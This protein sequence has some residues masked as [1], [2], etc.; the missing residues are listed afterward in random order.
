MTLRLTSLVFS[1]VVAVGAC[2]SA[3]RSAVSTDKMTE[4]STIGAKSQLDPRCVH[5]VAG[6]CD[7]Y[8]LSLIEL[9]AR[10]ERY[11]GRRVEVQ[12]FAN[13]EFEGNGLYVSRGDWENNVTKNAI[14]LDEPP[15]SAR[16]TEKWRWNKRYV[17]VQGRFNARRTDIMFSG[18]LEDITK[19][20][21]S[22]DSEK[23][24]VDEERKSD[25]Q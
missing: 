14:W 25:T 10:P 12:G 17:V 23:P 4:A 2:S 5:W 20:L 1:G 22:N 18:A 8:F 21:E 9:I 3:P 19:Y 15:S 16:G 7:V 24:R 6:R 13:L 11:D